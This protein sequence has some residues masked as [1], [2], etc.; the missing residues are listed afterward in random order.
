MSNSQ[1]KKLKLVLQK[2]VLKYMVKNGTLSSNAI[3]D[4]NDKTNFPHK[5]LLTKAQIPR[6]YKALQMVHQLI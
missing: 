2:M 4:S 5:L 6:M 3:S 1:L